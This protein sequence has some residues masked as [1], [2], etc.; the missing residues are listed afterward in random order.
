ME[1]SQLN[2]LE[3][4]ASLVLKCVSNSQASRLTHLLIKLRHRHL[5]FGLVSDQC[6][7]T[8]VKGTRSL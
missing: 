7:F 3:A 8:A 4:V 5:A 1:I 2:F 6:L